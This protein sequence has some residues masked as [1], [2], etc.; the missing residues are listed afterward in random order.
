MVRTLKIIPIAILALSLGACQALSF[1]SRGL[2]KNPAQASTEN[3]DISDYFTGRLNAGKS[4][5]DRHQYGA[6]LVAFKQARYDSRIAG[7][8]YNGMAIAYSH[9][10]RA[11]LAER[12]FLKAVSFQ[13][14]NKKFAH[15]LQLYYDR[16][17]EMGQVVNQWAQSLETKAAPAEVSLSSTLAAREDMR[18]TD[19]A[20]I[21][22]IAPQARLSKSSAREYQLLTGDEVPG[23]RLAD[24]ESGK[25]LGRLV[26]GGPD[27]RATRLAKI[28][29]ASPRYDM[30]PTSIRIIMRGNYS[31]DE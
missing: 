9:L 20:T 10:G 24:W 13:P 15:N 27:I 16:S 30:P 22:I 31:A 8:A 3:I 1:G 25:K 5:L 17:V 4:L 11:D 21:R 29:F 18:Q 28:S 19:R 23:S 2:N 6:A 12:F 7:D 26:T 14:E